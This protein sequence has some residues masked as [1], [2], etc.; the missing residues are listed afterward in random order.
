M[1]YTIGSWNWIYVNIWIAI[2]LMNK[3]F[4]EYGYK[5]LNG[6][7]MWAYVSHYLII[8]MVEK[9]VVRPNGMT[10]VP[11]FMTAFALTEVG[12]IASY[13]MLT[14]AFGGSKKEKVPAAK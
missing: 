9:W 3:K 11:A 6:S 12:I 2:A 10:F 7:S 4:N 13:L 5:L 1:T 14:Y 8:V